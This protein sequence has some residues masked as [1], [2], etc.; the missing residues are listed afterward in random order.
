[1]HLVFKL[2]VMS[3]DHGETA[4]VSIHLVFKMWLIGTGSEKG[5]C[6][7]V[8]PVA[9]EEG[10]RVWMFHLHVEG[11]PPARG[12]LTRFLRLRMGLRA[13]CS[14]GAE[15]PVACCPWRR[16]L[17]GCSTCSHWCRCAPTLSHVA[18]PLRLLIASFT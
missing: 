2:R 5:G 14:P 1:M 17:V 15:P 12:G 7:Q 16:N 6:V 10:R 3:L 11:R 8:P 13:L 18:S 9:P 4:V